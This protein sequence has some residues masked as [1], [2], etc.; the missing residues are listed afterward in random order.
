MNVLLI[1]GT[2]V[3]SR[4]IS[5]EILS[6]GMNLYMLN[7]GNRPSEIPD[8]A[9]LIK[10]D[11]RNAQ[12]VTEKIADL[13]FDV[14]IDFL[15]FTPEQIKTTL[16]LFEK[17]C[18]Q[19]IFI[20]SATAYSVDVRE[21]LITED[22]EMGNR[23]WDY[24]NNKAV[25]ENILK[26]YCDGRELQYTIVRPYVTYGDTRIPFAVISGAKKWSLVNRILQGKPIVMWD[27]GSAICTLTH[28]EDFAVGI[29]GLFGNPKAINQAFH[30][31]SGETFTWDEVLTFISKQVG[32]EAI[33]IY[34]PSEFIENEMKEYKGLLLGDKATNM[35]FDNSKI[36]DAVP[37]FNCTIS[38]AEGIKRAVSY[39]QTHPEW[40]G[41]DHGWDARIDQLILK[42]SKQNDLKNIKRSSLKY[43]PC[44]GD[45][46]KDRLAYEVARRKS[47]ALLFKVLR[48]ILRILRK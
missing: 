46:F 27:D 40:M 11:I 33:R 14:V 22:S 43:I 7:R 3:L 48:R 30:I 34:I 12:D 17:K 32:K 35:T 31:T 8:Q 26:S 20:S 45:T 41:I 1:G 36:K 38:F 19:F 2:G 44:E 24:A 6:K 4:D 5:K 18:K 28:T 16:P 10:A 23:L 29:V 39:H 21:S 13:N 9:T 15:S 47:L 42:Y 25:C 37:E